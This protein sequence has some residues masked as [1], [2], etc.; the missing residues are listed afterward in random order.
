[1]FEIPSIQNYWCKRIIDVKDFPLVTVSQQSPPHTHTHIHIC[2]HTYT[3]SLGSAALSLDSSGRN[4]DDMPEF[5]SRQLSFNCQYLCSF[6]KAVKSSCFDFQP[7]SLP[8]FFLRAAHT[9]STDL[10]SAHWV[11]T[12]HTWL[13]T[14]CSFLCLELESLKASEKWIVFDGSHYILTCYVHFR[15]EFN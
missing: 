13:L 3:L 14:T 9:R 10:C 2:T 6:L 7:I 1:M 15:K 12:K 11:K 4:I 5:K 8:S